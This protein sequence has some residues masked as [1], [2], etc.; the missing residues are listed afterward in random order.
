MKQIKKQGV[1][2][3]LLILAT[4]FLFSCSKE[5]LIPMESLGLEVQSPYGKWKLGGYGKSDSDQK[6]VVMAKDPKAFF[7]TL[8]KD[9]TFT[10]TSST[11]EIAGK[12]TMDLSRRTMSFLSSGFDTTHKNETNDGNTYLDCLFKVKNYR[13]FTDQ[14]HLYYSDKDYLFFIKSSQQ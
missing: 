1:R 8:S 6:T 12:Y 3:V 4:S 7:L 10:G 2:W 13:V 9:S 5:A 11:N 14:L